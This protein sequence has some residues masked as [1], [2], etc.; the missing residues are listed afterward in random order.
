MERSNHI[1]GWIVLLSFLLMGI[2]F[3]S[4]ASA[5]TK[6]K[7]GKDLKV[8]V[9]FI[10]PVNDGGYNSAAYLGLEKVKSTLG[11]QTAYS[12]IAFAD[13]ELTLRNYGAQGFDI[14]FGHSG[15]IQEGIKRIAPQF[16][17]TRYILLAGRADGIAN[18]TAID[19]KRDDIGFLA[20]IVAG[21]IS[22]TGKA[23]IVQGMEFP[24][25]RMIQAGHELGVKT[26]NPQARVFSSY[27]GTFDD[28]VKGKEAALA[29]ISQG[30]DV[31]AHNAGWGGTGMIQAVKEKNVFAI[32]YPCDQNNLA[33]KN[34]ATSIDVRF[35]ETILDMVKKYTTDETK[36]G[37]IDMTIV[38]GGI[39]LSPSHGLIQADQQKKID[40]VIKRVKSGE[41]I[42]DTKKK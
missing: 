35:D 18:L 1:T 40:G 9:V 19:Y 41:L 6:K 23:G 10:G 17:N 8:A 2:V 21:V 38:N 14:V 20:G 3:H 37:T 24:S 7:S 29:Q 39:V 27:L 26:V 11:A 32:G 28:M 34:V 16:P 25:T 4:T 31:I 30:V 12:E 5:Q 42:V 36:P 15:T 13:V 22:K 33:P